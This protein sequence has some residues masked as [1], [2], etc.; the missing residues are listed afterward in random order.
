MGINKKKTWLLVGVTVIVN[1]LRMRHYYCE[2]S[3]DEA[4]YVAWAWALPLVHHYHVQIICIH[5]IN[6]L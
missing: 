2:F 6:F 3:K 1:S 4:P 5:L